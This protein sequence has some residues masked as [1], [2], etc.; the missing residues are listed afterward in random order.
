MQHALEVAERAAEFFGALVGR[1]DHHDAAEQAGEFGQPAPFPV[2]AVGRDGIRE[3][4]DQT[5]AVL[6][7]HRQHERGH[8][9]TLAGPSLARPLTLAT[10]RVTDVG[11]RRKPERAR[12]QM[13]TFKYRLTRASTVVS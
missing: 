12:Q 5:G 3:R 8:A 1:L 4:L 10:R 11:V 7:D 6:T 13:E 9:L 2:A